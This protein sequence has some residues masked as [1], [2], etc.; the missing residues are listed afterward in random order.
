LFVYL[1]SLLELKR[2]ASAS[3]GLKDRHRLSRHCGATGL[4]PLVGGS[5][6]EHF[7]EKLLWLGATVRDGPGRLNG[8]GGLSVGEKLGGGPSASLIIKE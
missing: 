8:N 6:K 2:Q 1:A 3:G 4:S 7:A 5:L